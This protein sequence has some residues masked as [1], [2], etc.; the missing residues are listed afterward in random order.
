[1]TT[2]LVTSFDRWVGQNNIST[3][4]EYAKGWW[5]YVEIVQRFGRKFDVADVTVIGHYTMRTPPRKRRSRWTN[6]TSRR[7]CCS[8]FT[9]R[10][11][12]RKTSHGVSVHQVPSD[13]LWGFVIRARSSAAR[14]PTI[15][16]R[17]DPTSGRGKFRAMTSL[18]SR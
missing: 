1:M 16:S 6:G 3:T 2:P 15:S 13:P 14:T 17:I 4:F 18:A 12:S 10:R 9:N 5:D 11:R 8:C 7:C